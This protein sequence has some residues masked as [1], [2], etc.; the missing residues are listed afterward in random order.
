MSSRSACQTATSRFPLEDYSTG[1]IAG[2]TVR[3]L[4]KHH[5][6]PFA[7]WVSFPDPHEPWVAPARY[8]AMFPP[9]SIQMPPWHDD[10]FDD[11]APERNR[12]LNRMLGV[13]QDDP[14]DVRRL[15][16]VYH[17]MVR[18]IDDALGQI[19][20]ALDDLG[21]REN[22]IVVFC[23]DHG[24]FM[25]EHGMQCKGGVFY[26]CL[27]RVPLIISWPGQIP[28]GER[29]GS[30]VSLIDIVPTVLGLQGLDAPRSMHGRPLPTVTGAPRRDAAFSEYG[31]GGPPF[32]T[33]DLERL[34]EPCGRRALMASL[35]WREA[36]GRRKMVRTREWK[37]VHDSMRDRDELYDL[38]GDP[39]ELT[40][41]VDD[42]AN[43]DVLSE[44]RL[45]LADWLIETE[46]AP[47]VPLPERDRYDLGCLAKR[48]V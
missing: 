10:E 32:R 14:D 42:P 46:D 16:G 36:E 40:N 8:A 12:V 9:D 18:F 39:W 11:R 20:R 2:Q 5:G 44:M 15:M 48:A 19:M 31:A 33:E 45:R 38:R 26:D 21:L 37:Y 17:G 22:T 25:G 35:Q 28:E 3:F 27:T 30:M 23:S 1:L 29:E 4:E 34:P 41:V 7:L 13:G 43:R 47:P 24:D 6:E